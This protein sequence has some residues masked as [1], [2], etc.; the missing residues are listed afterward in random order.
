MQSPVISQFFKN[1][2]CIRTLIE[3]IY[4]L[5]SGAPQK[6]PKGVNEALELWNVASQLR[7]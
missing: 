7:I 6:G 3:V 2:D 1:L 4:S 5:D